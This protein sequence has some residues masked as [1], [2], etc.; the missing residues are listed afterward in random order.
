MFEGPVGEAGVSSNCGSGG[1]KMKC[2]FLHAAD[3][4]LDSPL[5]GLGSKS[6]E[7]ARQVAHASRTAFDNLV[8][9]AIER[10]CNF[11]VLA[12]DIF[13]GE[14]RD[15]KTGIFFAS[16]MR[17]LADAGIQVF[18]VLGNHDA[19]N[20]FIA[21]LEL[22]GNVRVLSSR[23]AET[24]DLQDLEV[25]I[26]GRSFPRRDVKE[27]LVASYPAPVKARFNI[28]M[29]HTACGRSGHENYAPCSLDELVNKGYDYWALGHVHVREVLHE[30]PHVIFPGNL[31]GRHARETGPKGATIVTVEHGKVQAIEACE[32]D[33]IRWCQLNIDVGEAQDVYGVA[34]IVRDEIDAARQ[35]AN[36]RSLALRVRLVGRTSLHHTLI[37]RERTVV[38]EIE[39]SAAT[40]ADD[41]WI[42]KVEIETQPAI[43][44]EGVDPTVSGLI[45]A[46]IAELGDGAFANAAV[47][48]ALHELSTKFP[49]GAHRD[50]VFARIR[51][52]AGARADAIA[53]ATIDSAG[54]APR[55]A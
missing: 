43:H 44:A 52:D 29:L 50:D 5:I 41:I 19:E 1:R 16:R 47:E 11:V 14:W 45:Q 3:L 4:H 25:A 20:R 36:G 38:E 21:R 15:W 17:R 24:V 12:G 54:E 8:D 49:N 51:L 42:E 23:A 2:T 53:Q 33:A 27:D 26:H 35:D 32:L 46:A 7:L 55:E 28:G 39:T 18:I 22:S 6:P 37:V 30:N 13:D 48:A 9:T 10:G 34:A 31:Q 40:V